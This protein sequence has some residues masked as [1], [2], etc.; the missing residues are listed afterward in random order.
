[1]TSTRPQELDLTMEVGEAKETVE[2]VA[3]V[4]HLDTENAVTAQVVDSHAVANLPLNERNPWQLITLSAGVVGTAG[5]IYSGFNNIVINGGR[6]ANNVILVDG[7]SATVALAGDQNS[8]SSAFPNV[9]MIQEFKVESNYSAEFGRSG[10]GIINLI[11]KS[12]TNS[13]HGNLYEFLRN[14]DLDSNDFFSNRNGIALPVFRRNQFGGTVGGPVY[15]PKLYHGQNRTF[16][17]FGYEALKQ[18]TA[19][20]LTTSVPTA[21][22]AQGDFSQTKAASGA[23]VTIY[24]PLTTAASGSAFVRTPFPGNI[25]PSARIDPVAASVFKYYPSPNRPG[26]ANTGLNN[27]F[28]ST[29]SPENI[30]ST[31]AKIDEPLNDRNRF[32]VR[33]SR[34][35]VSQPA[36]RQLP[37]ADLVAE[38]A[39]DVTE[40]FFNGAA[41]YTF[42]VSPT[43]LIDVRY[44]YGRVAVDTVPLGAGFNPVKLGFPAYIH[45]RPLRP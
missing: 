28:A 37:S 20:T 3:D 42:T 13:L 7:I 6:S 33:V 22:Q 29:A 26:I 5:D 17:M 10:G 36:A 32:F 24:D 34:H 45:P 11:Y 41:D 43:F 31:D 18:S 14:S 30:Y 2:V 8:G 40:G 27:Y 35:T 38:S 15:I 44:G 16:F 19:T 39:S 25:I 23:D 21:L 9:D 12:G 4:A 1:M